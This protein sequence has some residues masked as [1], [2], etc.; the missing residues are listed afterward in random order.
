[1]FQFASEDVE[2]FGALLND[3]AAIK[4][5]GARF[6]ILAS[7]R[8]DHRHRFDEVASL[9]LLSGR[10]QVRTPDAAERFFDLAPAS[11]RRSA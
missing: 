7:M 8:S 10:D 6:I 9:A 3:M 2:A 1:M 11:A 4:V 5:D